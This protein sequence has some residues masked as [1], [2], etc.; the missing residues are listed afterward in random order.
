MQHTVI[1]IYLIL[2]KPLIYIIAI[3]CYIAYYTLYMH[4]TYYLSHNSAFNS[5]VGMHWHWL[6]VV[7][8]DDLCDPL[9]LD[10]P[11]GACTP[12]TPPAVPTH[13]PSPAP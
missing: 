13:S 10:D 8:D 6:A 2:I 5:C 11:A 7:P 1:Y 12:P 3:K 9:P 4:C